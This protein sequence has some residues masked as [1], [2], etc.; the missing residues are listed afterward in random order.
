MRRPSKAHRAG[1][2]I[3]L[4]GHGHTV[5]FS[6]KVF[7]PLT[8]LCRDVCHYC[9]FAQAPHA[10]RAALSAARSRARDRAGRAGRRL[11]GSAVH[12]GRPAGAALRRRAR[13]RC[14]ALGAELHAGLSGIL[15]GTRIARNR[16]AAAS[17]PRRHGREL[18][19]P[20]A[21]ASPSRKASCWRRRPTRL[22][23]ARRPALR[24]AR[25]GARPCAWQRS[26]PRGEPACRSPPAS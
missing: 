16:P 13:R 8:R 1:G 7:I 24:L 15:R 21:Q 11:Q 2:T 18:A 4:A 6:K 22:S 9:T 10:R 3:C 25:Q 23:R 26:K 12:A 5:S 17:Q 19:A 20:A 14:D